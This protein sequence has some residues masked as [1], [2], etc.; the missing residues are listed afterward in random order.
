LENETGRGDNDLIMYLRN[1]EKWWIIFLSV[2][3]RGL[4]SPRVFFDEMIKDR[5]RVLCEL[6]EV[7]EGQ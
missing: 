3:Q 2:G 5:S 4:C 7:G 6:G 1:L